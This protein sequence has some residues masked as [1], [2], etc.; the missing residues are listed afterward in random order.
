[1]VAIGAFA[2]EFTSMN[3]R[4]AVPAQPIGL[5]RREESR[6]R[7]SNSGAVIERNVSEVWR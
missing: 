4:H 2:H 3:S 5:S 7:R 6:L 1:V